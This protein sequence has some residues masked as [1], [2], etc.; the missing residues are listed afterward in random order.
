MAPSPER[1]ETLLFI[2]TVFLFSTMS[3]QQETGFLCVSEGGEKMFVVQLYAS[4]LRLV[5]HMVNLSYIIKNVRSVKQNVLVML[6][7]RPYSLPTNNISYRECS[8]NKIY[9]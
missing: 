4:S 3:I 2:R 5:I 8:F 1:A 9:G 7:E 6:I